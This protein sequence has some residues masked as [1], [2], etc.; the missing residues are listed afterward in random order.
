[1]TPRQARY[2]IAGTR[3]PSEPDQPTC[4][5]C[6]STGAP[7][8]LL[9]EKARTEGYAVRQRLCLPCIARA[10][11]QATGW[12]VVRA[13]A[14]WLASSKVAAGLNIADGYWSGE[15]K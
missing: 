3:A 14:Q 1:M 4:A 12:K 13:W 7:A 6:R 10:V 5:G 9:L 15:D 11:E 8:I 2:T